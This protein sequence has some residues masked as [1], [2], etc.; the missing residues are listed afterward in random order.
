MSAALDTALLLQAYAAGI[1]PMAE[2]RDAKEIFWVDPERRG[3]IPLNGFH[4]SRSLRRRLLSWPHDVRVNTDF[5]G[6]VRA[7]ADRPETWINDA[8]FEAY[9][10]LHRQGRA[11][12]LEIWSEGALSGGVYG[13]ILGGAFFGESMF[14]RTRDA[15][16]MALAYLVDR[17]RQGGFALFDVQF[18][19]P[20]LASLGAVEIP[21]AEY[22]RRL[23]AALALD[24][25]FFR[26]GQPSSGI[27]SGSSGSS[28]SGAG[29]A[30]GMLQRMSHT[31]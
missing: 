25:D 30:S 4:I 23:K 31:S 20:H 21:R 5:A 6:V 26:A 27:I 17:L 10:A 1:F 13:V 19:T 7:C 12:S 29:S 15:S 22:R 11:H 16:K 28:A 14:S 3:V 2:T 18:L 8:I 9:L 24:A